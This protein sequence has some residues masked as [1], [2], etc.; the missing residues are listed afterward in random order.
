METT[1][2]EDQTLPPWVSKMDE[3]LDPLGDALSFIIKGHLLV[4]AALRDRLFEAGVS[5]TRLKD[6]TANLVIERAKELADTTLEQDQIWLAMFA[7]NKLRNRVGHELETG[8]C[9]ELLDQLFL[10]WP[11]DA[12]SIHDPNM[13]MPI[14]M[15]IGYL[16]AFSQLIVL[17][18]VNP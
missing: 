6:M 13:T 18:K 7:L 10:T 8:D 15:S 1:L 11:H 4:E 14:N 12:T 3:H 17:S 2:T 16:I 9:A 5:R